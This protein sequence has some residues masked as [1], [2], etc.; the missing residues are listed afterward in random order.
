MTTVQLATDQADA[1]A[2]EAIETHHAELA[3]GLALK[4]DALRRAAHDDARRPAARDGLVAWCHAE[5]L[6][7]A[8]AE[9][10]VLYAAARALPE[11]RLL[12]TAMSDEHDILASL[13]ATLDT[14]DD[15]DELVGAATALRT[16]FDSHVAKENELLLPALAADAATSL[17]GLLDGMHTALDAPAG[18]QATG[19]DEPGTAGETSGGHTCGCHEHDGEGPPE[20]DV[21]QVPHAI[22]HATVFGALEAIGPGTAMVLVAPHDPLPLLSQIEQQHPGRFDVNYL[23]RGPEAWRLR[24]HRSA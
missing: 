2:L 20:L 3:G 7:H 10:E 9:E 5:L 21:R 14:A 12:V 22:R 23:E 8:Q 24:L 15:P 6:P 16:L 1:Q 18:H 19:N 13:V 17:A 4:I 11:V